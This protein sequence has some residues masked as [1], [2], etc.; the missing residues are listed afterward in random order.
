VR[1]GGGVAGK[2][3]VG[4]ERD[5]RLARSRRKRGAVCEQL[6]LLAG[7]S[8]RFL[9]GIVNIGKVQVAQAPLWQRKAGKENQWDTDK[10]AEPAILRFEKAL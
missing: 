6:D 8:S 9:K 1:K 10:Q 4:R 5:S 2:R 3:A 7:R